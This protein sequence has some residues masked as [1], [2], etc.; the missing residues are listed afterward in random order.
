VLAPAQLAA[1]TNVLLV[2]S[3]GPSLLVF[4]LG[5]VDFGFQRV[6]GHG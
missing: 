5:A 6:V 2:D 4:Q 3:V 1:G